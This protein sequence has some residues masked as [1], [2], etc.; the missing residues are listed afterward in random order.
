MSYSKF[1]IIRLNVINNRTIIQ[2]YFY[3]NILLN[4][5]RNIHHSKYTTTTSIPRHLKY[6]KCV[7][8]CY[9]QFLGEV[10]GGGCHMIYN[11]HTFL[12]VF[13]QTNIKSIMILTLKTAQVIHVD[14]RFLWRY[15]SA[16]QSCISL[17]L[18]TKKFVFNT[19]LNHFDT[20][21]EDRE[22]RRHLFF[23]YLYCILLRNKLRQSASCKLQTYML[24]AVRNSLITPVS[25]ILC[26]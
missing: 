6:K 11:S 7:Y 9:F 19:I 26:F 3:L 22:I 18:T 20:S 13:V 10:G 2:K 1:G 25:S 24:K 8:F 16:V 14:F 17:K 12:I 15:F 4:K 21:Q 23:F 5:N